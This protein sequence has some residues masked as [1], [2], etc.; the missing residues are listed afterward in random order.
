MEVAAGMFLQHRLAKRGIM[1]RVA[2]H[3][4]KNLVSAVVH[5]EVPR[6]RDVCNSF[7]E[8]KGPN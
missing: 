6:S 3:A 2:M 8:T 5:A 1:D 7:I 4:T